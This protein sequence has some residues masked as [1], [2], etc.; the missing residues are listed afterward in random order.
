MADSPEQREERYNALCDRALEFVMSKGGIVPEDMLITHVFGSSGSPALWRPLLRDILVHDERLV[1]HANGEWAML[2]DEAELLFDETLLD[3]FVALDVETT[4]LKPSRQRVIEVALVRFRNG[5][6]ERSFETLL[7]PERAIPEFITRLTTIR[8][9]DVAEAPKFADV[10]EEMLEFLG[11]SLIIGHNVSFDINFMNAELERV[12]RE[13]LVNERLDTMGMAVRFLRSLRKPSLDRVADAVGLSPRK[14]H[15]AGGDARLTGEVAFRLVQEAMRQGVTSLDQMKAS[16]QVRT[17]RVRDD[18]GRTRSVWDRSLAHAMPKKTGV[19]LMKNELGEIVYVGKAKNLR[20]RVSSYYS[21]PIGY[22]RKMDGLVEAVKEI[23][24]VVVGSELEA[25][26]L[27]SQLIRRLQ[28][29]YN[30]A[31]KRTEH[32]PFIKVDIANA[33]PRV[34]LA[35]G[36]KDDGARYYGPYRSANSARKTVDVI[37]QV[38]PLR[39]C[40]RS[41]KDARSYGKPCIALDLGQCL[42]PCM[43]RADHDEYRRSVDAVVNFLDGRDE[44]LNE[45]LLE[46]LQ[47]AALRLD[48]EKAGRLRRDIRSVQSI[49][50]EQARLRSAEELHN[51]LLV[52]PS[53][54]PE[55]RE[56]LVVVRGRLWA[57]LKTSR[58]PEIEGAANGVDV[59]DDG[60]ISEMPVERHA[61]AGEQV[62]DLAERLERSL[63]RARTSPPVMRDHASIDETAILN[64]FLFRNAGH[65]ALIPIPRSD[66]GV[67]MGDPLAIARQ[68]LS[69]PDDIL[70]TLDA[71]KADDKESGE[72][73]DSRDA[74]GIDAAD[75]GSL[76]EA[77]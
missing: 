3:E 38:L 32:Y 19:Y 45:R 15:R 68:A 75:A 43:G 48:F 70:Q 14:I 51:L 76:N 52:L 54:E 36:I 77:L 60:V 12:D 29:R 46:E 59:D 72:D 1:F 73:V 63:E 64:R 62:R 28:P 13:P 49:V 27:E 67:L 5:Q 50:E 11:D 17:P 69:L 30:T 10:A 44:A 47:G 56:I 16:A 34:L 18:V 24:H 41:F 4:G 37:N 22:T 31:L 9:E 2:R 58:V 35:K 42:G 74:A 20:D 61:G 57:Q 8:N 40:T 71:K 39:T 33:W 6:V 53:A 25:L 21:Q 66:D 7:N 23:D 65:P 55:H 26:L